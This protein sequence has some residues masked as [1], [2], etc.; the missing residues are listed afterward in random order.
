[1]T[2]D[3]YRDESRDND[4]VGGFTES[5]A[6]TLIQGPVDGVRDIVNT[7]ANHSVIPKI[8]LVKP[9]EKHEVGTNAWQAQ[10]VG[11]VAGLLS[12]FYVIGSLISRRR[13]F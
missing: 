8:Q 2:T 10:R 9:P 12:I 7:C 13:I 11:Q 6:H 5:F 3:G 1:M 4:M